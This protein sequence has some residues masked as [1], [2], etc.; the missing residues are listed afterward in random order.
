MQMFSGLLCEMRSVAL[1]NLMFIL[2][3]AFGAAYFGKLQRNS[4]L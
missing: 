2:L 3:N 4:Q 1:G